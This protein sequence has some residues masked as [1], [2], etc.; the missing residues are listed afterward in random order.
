MKLVIRIGTFYVKKEEWNGYQLKLS[1]GFYKNI[2]P[3]LMKS[4]SYVKKL[5]TISY[6]FSML[7][8]NLN[9]HE[10]SYN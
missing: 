4:W 2:R 9:I 8:K 5:D 6:K 3:Y 7:L 1:N 10:V